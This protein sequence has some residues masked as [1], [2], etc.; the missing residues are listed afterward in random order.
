MRVFILI[1]ALVLYS[2]P[3]AQAAG[4][5]CDVETGS[6]CRSE[7]FPLHRPD[8]AIKEPP[9]AP[10]KDRF[11]LEKGVRFE[12]DSP[13]C[14]SALCHCTNR[15][16]AQKAA[17]LGAKVLAAYA[18]PGAALIRGELNGQPFEVVISRERGCPVIEQR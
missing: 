15:M 10:P 6:N 1:A 4:V 12:L 5:N 9:A 16:I 3:G 11:A 13:E 7:P 17:Q 14:Q 2:S 18:F 8:P